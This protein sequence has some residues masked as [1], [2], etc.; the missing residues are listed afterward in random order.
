MDVAEVYDWFAQES[1]KAGKQATE[2]KQRET[3]LRL[4]LMWAT[5]AQQC[6]KAGSINAAGYLSIDAENGY[7]SIELID[8]AEN[9]TPRSLKMPLA[10]SSTAISLSGLWPPFGRFRRN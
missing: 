7:L 4:A 3:F 8:G 2:W 1:M 10:A 9:G 6:R 5:A